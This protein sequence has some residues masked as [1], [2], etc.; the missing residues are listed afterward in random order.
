MTN[1]NF[2]NEVMFSTIDESRLSKM[3]EV[4]ASIATQ[5]VRNIQQ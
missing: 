5:I 1:D 4:E 2:S 3:N